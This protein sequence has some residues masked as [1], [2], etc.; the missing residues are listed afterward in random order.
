MLLEIENVHKR[1]ERQEVLRGLSLG[2]EH[3]EIVCLLGASGSGK[4]TLLRIVAGLERADAGRVLF[5]GRPADAPG[6]SPVPPEKRALGMVFQD[7]ALWPHLSAIE[8]VALPLRARD[9]RDAF[10]QALRML[11]RVGLGGFAQRH[12]HELSGGQQQRVAL[13]RALAVHPKL[14][15]C[16]EPLSSLD[17][18]LRDEMRDLI[19]EVVREHGLSAV[20]ITHDRREAMALGDRVGVVGAG[21]LLQIDS[22]RNL[23]HRPRCEA[24]ARATGAFGPWPARITQTG[25]QAPWGLCHYHAGGADLPSDGRASL[26]LRPS[27]LRRLE[28]APSGH[29]SARARV[30]GS[31]V[32]GEGVE[33]RCDLHGVTLSL[34]AAEPLPAGATVA[35]AVDP[36]HS[37]LY[38]PETEPESLSA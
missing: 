37:L 28:P 11:E 4:T 30:L 7:Y 13:A 22:P 32:T 21:R 2:V 23:W 20:T 15:L 19:A 17:A 24:V 9:R 14:L 36:A 3:G 6:M 16:D 12:P 38:P 5:E 34:P 18:G 31:A 33:L 27:A 29:W 25:L 10:R 35:L 1:Y 26:Y 8:N